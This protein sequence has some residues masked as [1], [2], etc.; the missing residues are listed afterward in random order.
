[1][2][3]LFDDISMYFKP[4]SKIYLTYSNPSSGIMSYK[5]CCFTR[6]DIKY[7]FFFSSLSAVVVVFYL[8]V[9]VK[10]MIFL[11]LLLFILFCS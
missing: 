1:M 10:Y 2:K 3:Y 7:I 11:M 9:K 8:F 4:L 5:I 6:K